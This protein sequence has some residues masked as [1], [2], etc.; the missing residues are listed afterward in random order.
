MGHPAAREKGRK[1]AYLSILGS[2]A[3]QNRE[4]YPIPSQGRGVDVSS[5]ERLGVGEALPA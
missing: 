2:F 5:A 3:A 4:N 1:T